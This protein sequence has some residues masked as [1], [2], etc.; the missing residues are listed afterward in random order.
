VIGLDTNV[1]VRYLAQDYAAQS[2][3]AK[4]VME[5]LSPVEQGWISLVVLAELVW[6][7]KKTYKLEKDRIVNIV[8]G[9][10]ASKD[11][12]VQDGEKVQLALLLHRNNRAGFADCLLAV[13][14]RDA[15]CH[16][17]LTFDRIAA[18]DLGM[19]QVAEI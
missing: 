16:R 17:V 2:R 18:R 11:I 15:G 13:S 1:L 3:A 12:V 7:L 9:L 5:S 4:Q 19:E 6:S 8:E 10:L 14:A